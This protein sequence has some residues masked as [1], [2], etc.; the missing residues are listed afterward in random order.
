MVLM[1]NTKATLQICISCNR[2]DDAQEGSGENRPAECCKS[3]AKLFQKAQMALASDAA[4]SADV[5]L[6]PVECMSACSKSCTAALQA[7][8]KYSFVIGNLS[9]DGAQLDDLFAFAK[10]YNMAADGLPTWRTRPP[11]I[12]KNTLIRLHPAQAASV[13]VTSDDHS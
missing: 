12:R 6:E 1:K 9:A 4:L 7:P 11:F 5:T 8:G 10:L 13:A 3:G 2:I